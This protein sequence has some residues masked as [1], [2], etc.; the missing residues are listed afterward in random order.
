[1]LAPQ[2]VRERATRA[3]GEGG[4]RERLREIGK[5][6]ET[7]AEIRKA[8]AVSAGAGEVL[9]GTGRGE[10]RARATALTKINYHAA[11]S[12]S[13]TPGIRGAGTGRGGGGDGRGEEM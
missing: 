7:N 9:F 12:L 13:G 10:V 2:P 5:R 3:G 4:G 6:R 8:S 1:M 11:V